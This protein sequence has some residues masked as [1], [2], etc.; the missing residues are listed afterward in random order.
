MVAYFDAVRLFFR[1]Y[2]LNTTTAFYFVT[3]CSNIAVFV[4]LRVYMSQCIRTFPGFDQFSVPHCSGI[5]PSEQI[6]LRMRLKT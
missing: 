1:P 4:R 3:E 5:V 6:V 2:S